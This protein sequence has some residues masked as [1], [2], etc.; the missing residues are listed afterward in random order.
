MLIQPISNAIFGY[1]H[2]LKT[3]FKKGNLPTVTKGFY[4]E[5]I[6]KDTVTIE[7]LQLASSFKDKRQATT[8]GNIVLTSANKNQARGCKPL[9]EVI[10]YKAMGEYFEQFTKYSWGK[11]YITKCMK[12]ITRLIEKGM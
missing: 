10:N 6:D 9:S 2:Y 12:T 4:G 3:E 7:H 11:Q 1:S 5:P 8:W